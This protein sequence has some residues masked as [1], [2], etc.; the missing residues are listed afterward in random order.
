MIKY[1]PEAIANLI[2]LVQ[3][4]LEIVGGFLET[5][6]K[7]NCPVKTGNLRSSIGHEVEGL[8]VI[9]GTPVEYA[10][11]V[12]FGD[13]KGKVAKTTKNAMAT[14]PF[15]RPALYENLHT[16]IEILNGKLEKK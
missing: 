3:A 16:V 13:E 6:T 9:I 10:P 12:E 4:R 1:N 7:L 11:H 5:E 15:M 14:I 2:D 8:T